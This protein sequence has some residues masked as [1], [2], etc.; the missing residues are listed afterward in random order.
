MFNY[1]VTNHFDLS[2]AFTAAMIIWAN[3]FS[4]QFSIVR[5]ACIIADVNSAASSHTIHLGGPNK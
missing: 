2:F 4:L 5:I 1:N 3:Y